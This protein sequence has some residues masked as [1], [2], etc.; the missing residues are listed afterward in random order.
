MQHEFCRSHIILSEDSPTVIRNTDA[1]L[2]PPSS[3]GTTLPLVILR[4]ASA[5]SQDLTQC[6][7]HMWHGCCDY[8]QYDDF[9]YPHFGRVSR[10]PCPPLVDREPTMTTTKLWTNPNH[11]ARWDV[12]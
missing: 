9:P 6:P 2:R 10:A 7:H 4:G 12:K 8:A 1:H 11:G 3:C 5:E